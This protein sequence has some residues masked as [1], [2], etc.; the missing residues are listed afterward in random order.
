VTLFQPA[1]P[2]SLDQDWTLI[3]RLIVPII[4]QPALFP[5][6]SDRADVNLMTLQ[7]FS[8]YNMADGWNLTSSPVMTADWEATSGN[9]FTIP[10]GSGFGRIFNIG[11]QPIDAQIQ[12]FGYADKPQGGPN[13]TL[14]AQWTFLL[15]EG[16]RR[17]EGETD[18]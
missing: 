2:I 9:R 16:T 12:A 8:N 18:A 15:P 13:R 7:P 11:K 17:F 14:R 6:D 3:V 10:L 5:G 1:V 4:Y